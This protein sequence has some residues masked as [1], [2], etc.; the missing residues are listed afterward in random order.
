MKVVKR[1][2]FAIL[3]A[4]VM[5]C[6]CLSGCGNTTGINESEEIDSTTQ[7]ELPSGK[8][9]FSVF[10]D[11]SGVELMN[12][13][14][15]GFKQEYAGQADF[16]I[17]VV[18]GDESTT[19][20]VVL[21]DINHAPD[22]FIL[23]DDQVNAMISAGAL[24]PVVNKDLISSENTPGS[25]EAVTY[26]GDIYAY[27]LTA[28]NGYFMYYNKAYFEP[29]DLEKLSTM[30]AVAEKK[31]KKITFDLTSAWYNFAFFG[32]TGLEVGLNED[33]ITNYCTWNSTEGEIK[34]V[35]ICQALLEICASPAFLPEGD[36]SLV[37]GAEDGSVIA[38]VSGVW[39]ANTI[40]EIWGDNYGA[41]K[42]PTYT[43]AG[44]EVQ[45]ASFT[46]YKLVGV[47]YY[48]KQLSWAHKFAEWLTNEQNQTL[49]FTYTSQGPSNIKAAASEEVGK[50]PA[51]VAVIEQSQY[52]KLQRVGNYY[53]TPGNEFGVTMAN[54]NPSGMPLQDIMDKLVEGITTSVAK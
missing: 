30:L 37:A 41:V 28:D 31:G 49:R 1:K 7:E 25:I 39:Q 34:G 36:G 19:K 11:D 20:V 14:I 17:T 40:K 42:L 46:G 8:V 23:P 16:D 53:W 44:Q 13:I 21:G 48:S 9:A 43:V 32:N 47:N 22:V 2:H 38:G 35:D 24:S 45:L 15:D 5:S 6:I 29:Q 52:G 10:C 33:G 3:M 18:P 27:P 54:L 50:E 12:T 26:K 51:I 4:V